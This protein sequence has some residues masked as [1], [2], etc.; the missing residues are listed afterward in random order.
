MPKALPLARRVAL[1]TGGARRLGRAT[2]LELAALGADVA[3]HARTS[4]REARALAALVR[5]KGRRAV[6]L[7]A[8]L[9]DPV[10]CAGLVPAVVAALG[11]I[12]VLV[13]NAAL[14]EPTDPASGDVASWDRLMDVNAR[15]TYLLTA[16]AGRRMRA[17]GG[18]CVVHLACASA[19]SPWPSFLP[20]SASKAAVVALTKGFAKAFAPTV[21][22][23]AVAP[24][25]I[26]AGGGQHPRARPGGDRR[27]GPPALGPPRR[28]RRRDPLPRGGR[29]VRDGG[30]D[31]GGRRAPPE[32]V[33]PPGEGRGLR[34]RGGTTIAVGAAKNS[35]P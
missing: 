6:V 15:A 7:E 12:D 33:G 28:H 23:N 14:F 5:R 30:R 20:Y 27:H 19:A 10:A 32:G 17:A 21:R 18:G 2:V 9:A 8:D 4:G 13:T 1:V 29:A 22:V 26:L 11:R 31:P 35:V 24:G 25:P 16:E 3:I 34:G